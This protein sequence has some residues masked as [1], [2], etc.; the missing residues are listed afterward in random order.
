MNNIA[1]YEIISYL[2]EAENQIIH[3]RK[4]INNKVSNDEIYSAI[5]P[6]ITE[7]RNADEW[8]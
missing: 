7:L 5:Q 8:C 6:A 3:I 1:Q 4:L 2:K